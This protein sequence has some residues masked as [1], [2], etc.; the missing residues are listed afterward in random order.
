M[1]LSALKTS[2]LS[3]DER[4]VLNMRPII[5]LLTALAFSTVGRAASADGLIFQLPP[6]GSWVRY[7][8]SDDADLE[9]EIGKDVKI[10][11]A[12]RKEL[13]AAMPRKMKDNTAS[14]TLSSV[15]KQEHNGEPH[16]WIEMTQDVEFPKTGKPGDDKSADKQ[17]RVITLKM[18]IPEK[19]LQAGADPLAHVSKLYFKDSDQPVKE[20][21][22]EKNKQY[23]LDRFRPIFP[24][25]HS[26]ARGTVRESVQS[27][28]EKIG[29]LECERLKFPSKYS[30]P[31]AGG[32][33]GWWE[34]SGDHQIWL[35]KSVPFGV[36]SLTFSGLSTESNQDKPEDSIIV[37]VK[38]TTRVIVAEIG[39]NAKSTLPGNN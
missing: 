35:H 8:V 23:Q 33:R 9:Y 26:D 5:L 36:A 21:T 14:L 11:E 20:V 34:W 4:D 27:P 25:P 17:S 19:Q 6:D 2:L 1:S 28:N 3:H 22:D 24:S 16:R 13:L 7:D 30:G 15:G 32:T 39:S 37:H 38:G 31:L 18:L 10:P 12:N 29:S